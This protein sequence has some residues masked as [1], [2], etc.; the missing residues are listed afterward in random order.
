MYT[1]VQTHINDPVYMQRESTGINTFSP[2][3]QEWI[4]LRGMIFFLIFSLYVP[5][6]SIMN[7]YSFYD[8]NLV[9]PYCMGTGQDELTSS[10]GHTKITTTPENNMRTS[11][12][13]QL[14]EI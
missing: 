8:Q 12:K 2:P 11:R 3:F 7:V 4:S 5:K 14:L 10:H 1:S 6:F 9:P 13:D